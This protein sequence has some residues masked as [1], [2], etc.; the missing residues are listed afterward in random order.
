MR[1]CWLGF[2]EVIAQQLNTKWPDNERLII[3]RRIVD[4]YGN[5]PV[6]SDMM[7]HCTMADKPH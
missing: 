3:G 2:D 1:S 6:R 5:V 4:I 7:W